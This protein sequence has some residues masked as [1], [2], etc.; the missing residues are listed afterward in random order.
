MPVSG[1]PRNRRFRRV[2]SGG[3]AP[4]RRASSRCAPPCAALLGLGARTGTLRVP[5]TTW[6]GISDSSHYPQ[7][8]SP[9]F[10]HIWHRPA[11]RAGQLSGSDLA[12]IRSGPTVKVREQPSPP[13]RL[14]A[15]GRAPGA[16]SS[17]PGRAGGEEGSSARSSNSSSPHYQPLTWTDDDVSVGIAQRRA[18]QQREGLVPQAREPTLLPRMPGRVAHIIPGRARLA[19]TPETA[20]RGW[21]LACRLQAHPR[22]H[23][24]AWNPIARSL[25]VEPRLPTVASPGAG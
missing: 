23:T 15:I 12:R 21:T 20:D 22:V 19:F 10:V 9:L 4:R 25:I 24:V 8:R 18:R 13:S 11:K 1:S 7:T 3:S 16:S 14:A 6:H 2:V 17:E 5:T